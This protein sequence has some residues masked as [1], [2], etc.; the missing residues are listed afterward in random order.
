MTKRD[1]TTLKN[2]VINILESCPQARDSDDK[3][4][5]EVCKTKNSNVSN[6]SF[7]NFMLHRKEYGIPSYAS[8]GRARRKAQEERP[9]LVG[10]VKELR[11]SQEPAYVDFAL[12]K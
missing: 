8:V 6:C 5:V 4:Y 3:L 12:N 9:D 2:I 1:L 10:T 7:E 11:K